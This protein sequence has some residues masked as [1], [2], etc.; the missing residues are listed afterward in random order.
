M[1]TRYMRTN[2]NRLD[3]IG[4]SKTYGPLSSIIVWLPAVAHTAE[5]SVHLEN[6][7]IDFQS[8]LLLSFQSVRVS[9]ANPVAQQDL[10]HI[11][12]R[13]RKIRHFKYVKLS[14]K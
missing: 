1:Y 12:V 11:P 10:S 9:L 7:L 2:S 13:K 8:N 3:I 5:L 4:R 6:G 14:W